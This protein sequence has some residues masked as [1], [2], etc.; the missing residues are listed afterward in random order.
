MKM[1]RSVLR[2]SGGASLPTEQ[3]PHLEDSLSCNVKAGNQSGDDNNDERPVSKSELLEKPMQAC[4]KSLHVER[5]SGIG[6]SKDHSL[7]RG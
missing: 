6:N 4:G 3:C 7:R 1:S 5:K 2:I